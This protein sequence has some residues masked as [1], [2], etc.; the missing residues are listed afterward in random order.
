MTGFDKKYQERRTHARQ[1]WFPASAR[2]VDR[3][4]EESGMEVR[5]AIGEVPKE[6]K[7]Q[8][9][10]EERKFGAFLHIPVKD[11]YKTLAFKTLAFWQLVIEQYN[12]RYIIKVDDDNYV[13]LDRL[14]IAVR[15]WEESGAEYVGCFKIRNAA[16]E[17]LAQ[18]SHRWYDPHHKV[19]LGDDTR[20]AEGP[21]Y[22]IH[23]RVIE[24]I[25]RSGL[26]PRAGGPEDLMTGWLMKAFNVS[27]YDDRRLCF[28]EGCTPSMLAF[29][30]DHA[31][32]D[33]MD[34]ENKFQ[35]TLCCLDKAHSFEGRDECTDPSRA[36]AEGLR[37]MHVLHTNPNCATPTLNQENELPMYSYYDMS[38]DWEWVAETMTQLR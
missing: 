23:G 21:F 1:T 24:G 18:R 10:E 37:C 26:L 28:M 8:I 20:Y 31:V 6:Y 9:A 30:W 3:L 36:H 11:H 35:R 38:S 32:R 13:R 12:A 17:R 25:M 33:Y 29:K 5:F 14:A 22:V 7:R 34:P 2:E 19:F 27:F 16:D 4:Y 15:Q